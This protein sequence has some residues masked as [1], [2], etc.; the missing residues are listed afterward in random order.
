MTGA[1]IAAT[2]TPPPTPW[3]MRGRMSMGLFRV[4]SGT[5][6]PLPAGLVPL[7]SGHRVVAVVRYLEGTLSYNELIIGRMA[8]RGHR[9]ALFIDHIWVDSRESVAGGRRIWG[10]PKELAEFLWKDDE[11]TIRDAAGPIAT[12]TMK[13]APALLPELGIVMPG[14]GVRDGR[15]LFFVGRVRARLRGSSL[16][17]GW[18]ASR[19]GTLADKPV[20]GMDGS[21]FEL[22]IGE[23][24]V[25]A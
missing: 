21:P 3:I 1:E 7:L 5:A 13:Q 11:V 23:A 24:R 2:V 10:L 16:R 15:L 22:N 4:K 19:F 18:L 8:R 20:L 14:F 6:D 12:L 9:F 25:L 17:I